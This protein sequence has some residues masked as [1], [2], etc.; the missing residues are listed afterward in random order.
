M[1]QYTLRNVPETLD[2][3]IREASRR[4]GKS[5]N[6]VTLE[7]LFRAFGLSDTPVQRRDLSDIVGT[8]EEDPAVERALEDQ[9]KIEADL[10]Q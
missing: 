4:Q 9:R 8:W 7:A 5:L 10:W 2:L 3:A 6:Q 1:K